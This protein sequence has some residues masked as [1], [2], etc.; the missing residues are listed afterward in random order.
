MGGI[1]LILSIVAVGYVF[2]W[3]LKRDELPRNTPDTSYLAVKDL[4]QQ[5][6]KKK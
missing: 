5:Q 6:K 3:S 2:F 4:A 1:L